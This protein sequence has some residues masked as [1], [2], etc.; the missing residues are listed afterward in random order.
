MKHKLTTLLDASDTQTIDGDDVEI[1]G[2][3]GMGF[4]EELD[5]P[6]SYTW[7]LDT[8][9]QER[10]LFNPDEEVELCGGG[11]QIT[12]WSPYQGREVEATLRLTISRAV[13]DF[14]VLTA[15]M[16]PHN[17]GD[18][19][20]VEPGVVV[21]VL[22]RGEALDRRFKPCPGY[23][24]SWDWDQEQ[25]DLYEIIGWRLAEVQA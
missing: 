4:P 12:L 18:P 3:F 21:E 6:A 8:A 14:D 15:G 9:D 17:P 5:A 11:A 1:F 10:Y 2:N 22:T 16:T 24:Y 13:E 23:A 19:C 20:P 7:Y 25:V